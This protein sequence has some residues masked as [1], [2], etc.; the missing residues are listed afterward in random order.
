[1][2]TLTN[3]LNT[4]WHNTTVDTLIADVYNDI[5]SK[6]EIDTLLANQT[7]TGSGNI[8]ITDNQLPL[9]FPLKSEWRNCDES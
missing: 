2:T 1:M 4:Y 5:Y 3:S 6:T 9:T 7:Y 8:D